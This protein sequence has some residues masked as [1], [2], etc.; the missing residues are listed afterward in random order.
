MQFYSGI[1]LIIINNDQRRKRKW[2]GRIGIYVHLK[3]DCNVGYSNID[4]RFV[5]TVSVL[6]LEYMVCEMIVENKN[7][8]PKRF[9]LYPEKYTAT[10]TMKINNMQ[11][12]VGAK[13]IQFGVNSNKSTIRNKLQGISLNQM[14]VRSWSYADYSIWCKFK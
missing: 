7:E 5:H 14:I 6:D 10:I 11:H 4:G 3:K 1:P 2:K 13:I 12:K 8:R 9:K